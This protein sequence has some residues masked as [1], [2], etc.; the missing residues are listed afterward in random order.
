MV[1]GCQKIIFLINYQYIDLENHHII[2]KPIGSKN[3][4]QIQRKITSNKG[5]CHVSKKRNK[6]VSMRVIIDGDASCLIIKGCGNFK[7]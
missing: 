7:A 6:N 1:M 3:K 5:L 4:K 2:F